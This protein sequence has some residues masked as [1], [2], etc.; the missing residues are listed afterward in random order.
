MNL[1]LIMASI[2]GGAI[3]IDYGVKSTRTAFAGTTS[4]PASSAPPGAA[5]AQHGAVSTS[6]LQTIGA[7]HG[8]TGAQ[9]N[10]W[11]HIITLESNGTL[12]DTNPSSGAYGIAQGITGPSWYYKY[13][14]NPSTVTGQLTAMANYISQRYGTPSNALS[15][16]LAH[17][18]Y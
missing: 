9:V 18:S 16:H 7:Q 17:G 8:W 13:G 11:M 3:V 15:F 2:L 6:D 1:A 4:A 12:T 5:P 14:G 10:D